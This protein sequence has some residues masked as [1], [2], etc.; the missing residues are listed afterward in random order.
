M[1]GCELNDS[2]GFFQP[3]LNVLQSDDQLLRWQASWLGTIARVPPKRCKLSILF[4]V[5]RPVLN[6]ETLEANE[7]SW[8]LGGLVSE[9]APLF[10]FSTAALNCVS[11]CGTN[12]KLESTYA[13]LEYH[14]NPC[15]PPREGSM[16]ST[17]GSPL[18]NVERKPPEGSPYGSNF[19]KQHNARV[20][21]LWSC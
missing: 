10:A 8:V 11:S 21:K 2:H 14:T 20:F 12:S 19:R 18:A 5:F 9:A 4:C 7:L 1:R 16:Q 17:V 13:K 3:R 6:L 15:L